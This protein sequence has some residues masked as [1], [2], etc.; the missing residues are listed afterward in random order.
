MLLFL[1]CSPAITYCTIRSFF[2]WW[3]ND[4][5]RL[6]NGPILYFGDYIKWVMFGLYFLFILCG[7]L[8]WFITILWNVATP[9]LSFNFFLKMLTKTEGVVREKKSHCFYLFMSPSDS[10]LGIHSLN[11][12]SPQA[13]PF[14][15]CPILLCVINLTVP[16]HLGQISK[17]NSR[18]ISWN[19]F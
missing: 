13:A 6:S 7:F 8:I 5:W 17:K 16:W 2:R 1:F 9:Y 10:C 4:Q 12:H 18:L 14:S 3:A 11:H 19:I 15:L